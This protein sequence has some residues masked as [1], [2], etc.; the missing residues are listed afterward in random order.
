MS[1][2]IKIEKKILEANDKA[3]KRN[4]Q[5]FGAMGTAVVNIMSSP[6]A[7]KTTLLEACLKR[8]SGKLN[9]GVIVGD[10]ATDHDAQRVKKAGAKWVVQINTGG[11][12]HLKAAMIEE[13][14]EAEAVSEKLDIII[15]ENVGNLVCPAGF[16]LGE[17]TRVMVGALTEGADKPKKYPAM[18]RACEI[19]VINKIDI[20]SAVNVSPQDFE[21]EALDVNPALKTFHVS[22]TKGDGIDEFCDWLSML[23][24]RQAK[25][26]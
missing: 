7:G 5:R 15:I 3:A 17:D 9:I 20:S 12:C 14:M 25:R 2:I 16:D 22:A 4:R 6:G 10:I 23:V 21:K 1:R 24:K 19:L 26:A 8:L 18:Y 11:T 13:A